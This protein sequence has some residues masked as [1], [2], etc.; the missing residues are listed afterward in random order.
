[1]K[2]L[3]SMESLV[4]AAVLC[5]AL[6][7]FPA[8]LRAQE[9]ADRLPIS[10]AQEEPPRTTPI[11]PGRPAKGDQP[12]EDL[13]DWS[14]TSVNPHVGALIYSGKFK[15]GPK[16]AG[17]LSAEA[18]MP[19]FS[20]DVIGLDQDSFGLFADVTVSAVD[21]DVQ[22]TSRTSGTVVLASLGSNY[23]FY[24]DQ[25]FRLQ[26]ELGVQYGYFGGAAGTQNGVA[27]LL[28]IDSMV[29]AFENCWVTF[30]PQVSFGRGDQVFH[31]SLG[32]QFQF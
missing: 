29:Q 22:S 28:G 21:R 10:L 24:E 12:A 5:G 1:M 4:Q 20:R 3:V 14:Q 26:G 19:W 13:V 15:A 11:P 17:G 30:N 31:L 16:F 2:R 7:S 8:A 23:T 6:A 32:V 27:F 18:P 9:P 25:R